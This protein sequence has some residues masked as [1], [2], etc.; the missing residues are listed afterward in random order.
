MAMTLDDDQWIDEFFMC[1]NSNENKEPLDIE[2]MSQN[3]EKE[4]E[5]LVNKKQCHGGDASKS[6]NFNV[7]NDKGKDRNCRISSNE[8]H[9]L[10][11]RERRKKMKSM[12]D[13][14]QD[15]IP[16]LTYKVNCYIQF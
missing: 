5:T 10:A 9:A 7:K 1:D 4:E 12:L 11:E 6:G 13:S 8:K 16:H 2:S 15:F 14:L 3:V